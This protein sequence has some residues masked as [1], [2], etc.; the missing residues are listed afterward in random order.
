MAGESLL[1]AAQSEA[2]KIPYKNIALNQNSLELALNAF[3]K[4]AQVNHQKLA[5]QQQI[6]AL[7]YKM[8]RDSEDSQFD[9]EK[10]A[11]QQK[12][13]AGEQARKIDALGVQAYYADQRNQRQQDTFNLVTA[14]KATQEEQ[15]GQFQSELTAA[16]AESPPGS[17]EFQNKLALIKDKYASV[18]PTPAGDKVL[19]HFDAEQ[20]AAAMQAHRHANDLRKNFDS[21]LQMSGQGFSRQDFLQPESIWGTDKG[22][23]FIAEYPV[24]SGNGKIS[25]QAINPSELEK[26]SVEDQQ[27]QYPNLRFKTM[28]EKNY[29]SLRA[30]HNRILAIGGPDLSEKPAVQDRR[31][32]VKGPDGSTGTLPE[33]QVQDALAAGYTLE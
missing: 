18:I 11:W 26:L 2:S 8:Q 3:A 27:K 28:P 33:S 14:R 19:R 9:H 16:A 6:E 1:E 32:R 24:D 10:F 23:K 25:W 21:S 17:Q 12:Y 30:M 31:V 20:N 4:T 22:N 29:N 15:A 13:Q 7:N 5:L